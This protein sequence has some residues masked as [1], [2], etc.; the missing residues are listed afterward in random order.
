[1]NRS[2]L[3]IIKIGLEGTKGIWSDE[4]P[5]VL[6]A[7]RTTTKT[8]IGETHFRLAYGSEVVIPAKIELTSFRVENHDKSRNDEAMHLQ[9]DLVDEVRATAKQRL[10]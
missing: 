9:L 2:L 4:L 10:T 5:S 7:Y 1:M 8:P 3:K 6:W